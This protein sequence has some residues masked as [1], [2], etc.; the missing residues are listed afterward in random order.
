MELIIFIIIIWSIFSKL[1][2]NTSISIES[3]LEKLDFTNIKKISA[4]NLLI[5]YTAIKNGENYLISYSLKREM[6]DST[7]VDLLYVKMDGMHFHKG[8]LIGLYRVAEDVRKYG[9]QYGIEVAAIGN[10]NTEYINIQYNIKKVKEDVN[11]VKNK[12]NY[13]NFEETSNSPI[14]EKIK[15]TSIISNL[16]KKPDRL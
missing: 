5:Y 8:L 7:D 10:L 12:T 3:K 15:G 11:V 6:L 16:F 2:N 4:S 9:L 1:S 13:N 14:K